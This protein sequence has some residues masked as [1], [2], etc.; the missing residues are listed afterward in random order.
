MSATLGGVAARGVTIKPWTKPVECDYH[1]SPFSAPWG[2]TTAELGRELHAIGAQFAVLEVDLNPGDFRQDGGPRGDRQTPRSP[3]L[4]LTFRAA[5]L[6]GSPLRSFEAGRYSPW[7]EN[8]RAL[9]LGLESLRRVDRYGITKHGEQYAGFLALP[10]G[11]T[12]LVDRGRVLIAEHGGDVRAALRAT[13]PDV[14]GN[15]D[16]F[17]AVQAARDADS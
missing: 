14:G 16:D 5:G 13:H 12:D 11:D 6:P 1:A 2:T 4:R 7:T 15:D 9:A 10:P 8:V 17:K 3:G